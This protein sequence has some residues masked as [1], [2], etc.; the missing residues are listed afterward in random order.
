MVRDPTHLNIKQD[1]FICPYAKVANMLFGCCLVGPSAFHHPVHI[2]AAECLGSKNSGVAEAS[3]AIRML[4]RKAGLAAK[5]CTP[6][7]LHSIFVTYYFCFT[8]SPDPEWDLW[9]IDNTAGWWLWDELG[10]DTK[11]DESPKF[12]GYCDW[13]LDASSVPYL[14]LF[15][16]T[17]MWRGLDQAGDGLIKCSFHR[18]VGWK[19]K[20]VG[21]IHHFLH[22]NCSPYLSLWSK[23]SCTGS[24]FFSFVLFSSLATSQAKAQNFAMKYLCILGVWSLGEAENNLL[25]DWFIHLLFI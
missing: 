23:V 8:R 25:S 6:L 19:V 1:C 24:S 11:D 20:E 5:P 4:F 21:K 18:Q 17:G 2:L 22:L 9:S 12:P 14:F 16:V 15:A 10:L 7:L 13:V 3:N